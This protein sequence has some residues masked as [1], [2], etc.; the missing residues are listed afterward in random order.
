MFGIKWV[1]L[2]V[3]SQSYAGEGK[4]QGMRV[5]NTEFL[6]A[7]RGKALQLG[8]GNRPSSFSNCQGRGKKAASSVKSQHHNPPLL[9]KNT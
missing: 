5:F 4:Q 7:E 3:D 9:T 8:E 2:S 1:L 6:S